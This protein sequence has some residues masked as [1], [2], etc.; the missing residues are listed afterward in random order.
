MS[1]KGDPWDNSMME[2]FFGL[3]KTEWIDGTCV[4]KNEA[5]LE[6]FK[7]IEMFCNPVRLHQY[8]DYVS[9]LD[10]E[11]KYEQVLEVNGEQRA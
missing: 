3:L 11:L 6:V 8:L 7:Y 4:T 9:P 2:S 1:R 5:E 10:F